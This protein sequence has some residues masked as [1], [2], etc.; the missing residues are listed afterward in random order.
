METLG[1]KAY[2][3][4]VMFV[5]DH[6]R[7]T[8]ARNSDGSIEI[9]DELLNKSMPKTD[10]NLY[11]GMGRKLACFPFI[12]GVVELVQR[13]YE[14][15][16]TATLNGILLFIGVSSLFLPSSG[17][18]GSHSE[19]WSWSLLLLALVVAACVLFLIFEI[20]FGPTGKYHAAEHMVANAL[21]R[22][23]KL[24]VSNVQMQSR[25][26]FRC[27]TNL[28]VFIGLV[29]LLLFPIKIWFI[30]KMVIAWSIGMEIFLVNHKLLNVVLKPFYWIGGLAQRFLFTSKPRTE[31]IEVAIACMKRLE[32]LE[33]CRPASRR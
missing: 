19:V 1:G 24:T 9:E 4:G 21:E 33:R 20:I 16:L 28:T 23:W 32:E 26:H 5:S 27:G 8:A 17:S 15:K 18:A 10:S 6:Y 13:S 14:N 31:H 22:G 30:L 12:R 11:K 25:V 29:I 3:N 7:V 2:R